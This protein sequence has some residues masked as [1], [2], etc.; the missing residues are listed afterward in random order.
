MTAFPAPDTS[1]RGC[2]SMA[3]GTTLQQLAGR[4][5]PYALRSTIRCR[6]DRSGRFRRHVTHPRLP[7]LS[8]TV[9]SDGSR[10]RSTR[11]QQAV[12]TGGCS[13]F[14]RRPFSILPIGDKR[15]FPSLTVSAPN[16]SQKY[17]LLQNRPDRGPGRRPCRPPPSRPVRRSGRG[18][19]STISLSPPKGI[20]IARCDVAPM[21]L[22]SR[23][24]RPMPSVPFWE[25]S[26]KVGE[27]ALTSKCSLSFSSL[28]H[29][30]LFQLQ[31][32]PDFP[33]GNWPNSLYTGTTSH[34]VSKTPVD[35]PKQPQTQPRPHCKIA[36]C[37]VAAISQVQGL[38]ARFLPS[39]P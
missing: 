13:N 26:P 3:A 12:A 11:T 17:N 5:S 25:V 18:D 38:P 20:G 8:A 7:R 1:N 35:G 15:A 14:P 2:P 16:S 4:T 19:V 28:L 10:T 32:S 39:L 31:N 36:R 22:K 29:F 34:L 27:P 30:G 37:D 23:P 6:T 9:P 33:F 21:L 24:T